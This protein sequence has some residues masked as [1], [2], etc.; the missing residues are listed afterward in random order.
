MK[1]RKLITIIFSA[2]IAAMMIVPSLITIFVYL[3][4]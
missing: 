2:A 4:K 3:I 1:K